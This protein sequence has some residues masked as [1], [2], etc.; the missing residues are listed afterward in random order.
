MSVPSVIVYLIVQVIV[1]DL[2]HVDMVSALSVLKPVFVE[3]TSF[4]QS[5]REKGMPMLKRMHLKED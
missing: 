5:A 3:E 1:Q 4:V 2:Y